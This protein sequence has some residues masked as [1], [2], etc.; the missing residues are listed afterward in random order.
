M[1]H[2]T[3]ATSILSTP[4]MLAFIMPG[5]P[6]WIIILIL[7][8]LIFGRRLPEVGRSLGRGIV[9]FKKGVKGIEEEIDSESSTPSPRLAEDSKAR[10]SDPPADT[11][12]APGAVPESAPPEA[13]AGVPEANVGGEGV[14]PY[15]PQEEP[16]KP[17]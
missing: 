12:A 16:P 17:G 7:G 8:L 14:N 6:E 13:S 9:E 3:V 11:G 2:M 5:G 4:T 10:L 1:T 15:A